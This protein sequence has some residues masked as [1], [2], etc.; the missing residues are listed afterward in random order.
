MMFVFKFITL[1]KVM[2]NRPVESSR[3]PCWPASVEPLNLKLRL[4][5]T[6]RR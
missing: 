1:L 5:R 3:S 2:L 6:Q 4:D